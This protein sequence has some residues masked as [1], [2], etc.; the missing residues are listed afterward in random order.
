MVFSANGVPSMAST[1]WDI[2]AD[3]GFKGYVNKATRGYVTG[4][5][6]GTP[7]DYQTNVHWYNVNAQYW[8]RAASDGTFK[9]PAMKPGTYTQV[10]YQTEYK[11]AETTVTVSSGSTTTKNIHNPLP[12][13]GRNTLFK[14][15]TY[16]GRPYGFKN[17]DKIECMHSSDNRMAN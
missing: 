9:S 16:D 7:S 2:I 10:L 4:K 13:E 17:A 8:V 3:M 11:A 5:A 12:S 14:I 1:N 6:T 15:G